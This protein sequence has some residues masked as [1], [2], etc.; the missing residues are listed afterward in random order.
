MLYDQLQFLAPDARSVL[1][2]CKRN[3]SYKNIVLAMKKIWS[4]RLVLHGTGVHVV[5]SVWSVVRFSFQFFVF[6][7]AYFAALRHAKGHKVTSAN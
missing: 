4:N 6:V 7:F 1:E 3:F 5:S 2:S